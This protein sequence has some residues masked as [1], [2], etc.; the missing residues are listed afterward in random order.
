MNMWT[1]LL[2]K[3]QDLKD[4]IKYRFSSERVYVLGLMSRIEQV[5]TQKRADL[6]E[7]EIRKKLSNGGLLKYEEAALSEAKALLNNRRGA[8]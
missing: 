5:A 7:V 3:I 2:M 8:L 6:I 4:K 1:K